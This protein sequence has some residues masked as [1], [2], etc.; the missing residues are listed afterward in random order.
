VTFLWVHGNNLTHRSDQGRRLEEPGKAT[1]DSSDDDTKDELPMV[2]PD[3]KKEASSNTTPLPYHEDGIDDDPKRDF[4]KKTTFAWAALLLPLILATI[5]V[6]TVHTTI[7]WRVVALNSLLTPIYFT[8]FV[9]T[10]FWMEGFT[11]KFP[12]GRYVFKL[13][14]FLM[15]S[16]YIIQTIPQTVSWSFGICVVVTAPIVGLYVIWCLIYWGSLEIKLALERRRAAQVVEPKKDN[17][18]SDS[19]EKITIT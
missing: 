1:H 17:S 8:A 5:A 2:N 12:M 13:V 19:S 16:P 7:T 10:S 15:F 6:A 18:V 9:I 14:P 11:H 4:Y 3:S